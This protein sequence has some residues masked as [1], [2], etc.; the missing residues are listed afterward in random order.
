[1]QH[2]GESEDITDPPLIRVAEGNFALWAANERYQCHW[3]GHSELVS[4]VSGG[5]NNGND[6]TITGLDA[7]PNNPNWTDDRLGDGDYVVR[8]LA[9]DSALV[10]KENCK[11]YPPDGNLKPVGLLQEYG[12]DSQ[13]MFGLMTGSFQ[14]NKSGGVLRKN[15]S[16]I[17]DE[18]NTTSHGTFKT[19]PITGNIIKNLDALRVS[20][21]DHNPGTYNDTDNCDWGLNSFNNGSCTNWG[22]PQSEIYLE[23]LRYFAGASANAS[24]TSDDSSFINNFISSD[25]EDKLSDLNYCA[26]INIIQFNASVNSY[27]DEFSGTAD[28]DGFT[29]L[30]TYIDAVGAGELINGNDY[31]IGE[32]TSTTTTDGLCTAKTLTGLSD[33]IGLCPE[34]PRLEGS[35]AIAGLAN[36]A[37]T[38]SIRDDLSDINTNEAEVTVKTYGVTLSPAIPKIEVPVPA[39]GGGGSTVT[40]LPA[41]RNADISGNC[42]IVDFK[43]VQPHTVANDGTPLE[44]SMS[45]GRTASR[46]ATM[47]RIW[48]AS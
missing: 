21:Y 13:I 38:T 19:A 8:V 48:P 29:S 15:V 6:S 9:C 45:T 16:A 24:F 11:A 18:I 14:H 3:N 4:T 28:L 33:A 2:D 23:S 47:T 44:N 32:G 31:F 1:M 46:A 42:A 40:I 26:P 17:I 10:G 37:R 36:Y 20:G 34:A 7:D 39:A 27:D 43:V 12:D 22:N 5:T 25:W 30:D 35:Y 41:C